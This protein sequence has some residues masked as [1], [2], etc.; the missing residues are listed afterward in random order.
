[1]LIAHDSSTQNAGA[2]CGCTAAGGSG[3][4]SG[5]VGFANV[6]FMDRNPGT[7]V[8]RDATITASRARLKHRRKCFLIHW[9]KDQAAGVAEAVVRCRLRTAAGWVGGL[10]LVRLGGPSEAMRAARRPYW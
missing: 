7:F 10:G 2:H 8:D 4:L 5:F 9:A 6:E 3:I 1:M